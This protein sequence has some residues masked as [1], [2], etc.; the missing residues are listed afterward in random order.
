MKV[1]TCPTL[2]PGFSRIR[3]KSSVYVT[4]RVGG[5]SAYGSCTLDGVFP[6]TGVFD[7]CT[8]NYALCN[9]PMNNCHTVPRTGLSGKWSYSGTLLTRQGKH[10]DRVGRKRTSGQYVWKFTIPTTWDVS[11]CDKCLSN[12][13][14]VGTQWCHSSDT[15]AESSGLTFSTAGTAWSTR[16]CLRSHYHDS[17]RVARPFLGSD[18]SWVKAVRVC[19]RWALILVIVII[20]R[21]MAYVYT[22]A[23]NI[24][25][26][27]KVKKC[28]SQ[29]H[30]GTRGEQ[31]CKSTRSLPSH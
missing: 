23:W 28:L 22:L 7:V 26:H 13:P 4:T 29:R 14:V 5:L 1:V 18:P 6:V 19:W 25:C 3:K 11:V 2:D 16:I 8:S 20:P 12:T 24:W 17:P 9:E 10:T 30:E 15:A 27:T 21:G 31:R